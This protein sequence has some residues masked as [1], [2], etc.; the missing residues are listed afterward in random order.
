LIKAELYPSGRPLVILERGLDANP[1]AWA[2]LQEALSR[3]IVGGSPTRTDVR[4][5]VFLAELDTVREVRRLFGQALDLGP[6][7]TG[8]LRQL[9]ADRRAREAAIADDT[10]V[11]EVAL[12]AEL[13]AAGFT[14]VLKSFQL[15]NLARIS[16]L[17]H[18]A[19]FSVPGAGK[20]TVALANYALGRARGE[21]TQLVVAAPIAAFDAWMEDS[22]ICLTPPPTLGLHLGLDAP[23]PQAE[24]LLTN[25]NRLANDYDRIRTH[26]SRG[27]TQIILDEAHRIKRG[28]RGVHGRASLDLAYAAARRDVL[29][30]TPAPQ[31]AHDLV[32]LMRF[33]YPGQDRQIL[34]PDAYFEKLG[35]DRDVLTA[36]S[37]AV[38]RYF[39]RT[40]KSELN[41]P[42]TDFQVV[43]RDMGPLQ[44][45]IYGALAGIYRGGFRLESRSRH[46][47]DRLGRIVMY[48]LEAA[49]NPML[50][51]AGSDQGDDPAFEHPPLPIRGD[52][53]LMDLLANY[54]RHETPWK[55]QEV[56]RIVTAAAARG[57]KVLVW[58]TFVRNLKALQRILAPFQPAIVH[59]G[60][61]S[62]PEVTDPAILTRENELRRFRS[63]PA[64]AVLLANPAAAGEGLSLH[65][66]CHHAVYLDRNFNAGQFLQS[67]DR[68]HRLGL[69]SDVTTRFT[70]LLSRGSIDDAVDARLRE[71][72]TALA[73]LMEDPGLVQVALPDPDA[74]EHDPVLASGDDLS[75]V[76][77]HLAQVASDAA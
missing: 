75:A 49:T 44:K 1:G 26:V 14:R 38:S 10:E 65:H 77:A 66:W 33:L 74:D 31:G 8:Q 50:L 19:D 53:A 39:V 47:F 36:T 70:L 37:A 67:Q 60:V 21:V 59:G 30:G 35:R 40:R 69:A 68:I 57:E 4:A 16:R 48:M 23:L 27:P 51:T 52:E 5:D 43:R 54:H 9:A 62:Q 3:G 20:T 2:R 17:P 12:A 72:V 24:L 58:S 7:L 63:D 25:Y 41:L 64:C 56:E 11:D 28:E 29:T 46:E 71:K 13:R 76:V 61:T 34:P 45:A 73:M 32:A 55:Y 22:A 18:A 6:A 42:R 15:H